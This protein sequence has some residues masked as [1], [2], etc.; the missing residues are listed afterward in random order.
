[1]C[2]MRLSNIQND[3]AGCPLKICLDPFESRSTMT[4]VMC[5][6]MRRPMLNERKCL[7]I[8]QLLIN[9]TIQERPPVAS[10]HL[11]LQPLLD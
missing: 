2:L 5:S 7:H 11:R 1:M 8:S 9:S 6:S 4:Q 10:W 3:V